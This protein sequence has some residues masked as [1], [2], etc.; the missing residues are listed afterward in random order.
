MNNERKEA[1]A[2]KAKEERAA[3]AA[4]QAFMA[5]REPAAAA[6][7][8]PAAEPHPPSR[9]SPGPGAPA[10]TGPPSERFQ[11]EALQNVL[12]EFETSKQLDLRELHRLADAE[13]AAEAV[14][15]PPPPE[16]TIA[17]IYG[18]AGWF[19]DTVT[20]E[21]TSGEKKAYGNTG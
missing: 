4:A 10:A 21:M 18:G 12:A 15:Q 11:Q 13:P 19:V 9:P 20:F 6:V 8:S 7:G 5:G 17:K 14:E 2:K 1:A 3:A 16:T